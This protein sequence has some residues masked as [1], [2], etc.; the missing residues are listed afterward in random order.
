MARERVSSSGHPGARLRRRLAL[1]LLGL[2]AGLAL[3]E[4][5]LRLRYD[6]LPSLAGVEG[7]R[8]AVH[9]GLAYDCATDLTPRDRGGL[10]AGAG[11]PGRT[12]WVLGDSVAN[13][14]GVRFEETYGALLAARLAAAEGR[15]VQV[16]NMA[17]PGAG[18]CGVLARL[19]QALGQGAPD[20]VLLGLF[21]DDLE[22]RAMVAVEGA[23][24]AFPDRVQQPLGRA[25][26][27]RS[28]LAN[29][30]WFAGLLGRADR[31]ERFVDSETRASLGPRVAGLVRQVEAAGGRAVVSLVAPVGTPRCAQPPTGRCAWMAE[32][33]AL[34]ARLL[35]DAGVE[36]A[37]L[38]GLWPDDPGLLLP[39][40]RPAELPIHPS[41]AGH[42]LLA[43]ALWPHVEAAAR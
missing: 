32:D 15:A 2:C 29:L 6:G 8:Y 3:A 30:A 43:E 18:A 16:V 4:G 37:D 20:L 10:V 1:S 28:Y 5:A 12:M 22:A 40:E 35:A 9:D 26:V 17:L 11:A 19:E 42:R 31:Q 41:A 34:M 14:Q 23:P 13:G 39:Q 36:V 7:S 21:T 27:S 33:G 38:R 25:L 24:V